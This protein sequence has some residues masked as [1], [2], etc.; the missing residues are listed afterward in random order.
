MTLTVYSVVIIISSHHHP[1]TA[2]PDTDVANKDPKVPGANRKIGHARQH[3]SNPISTFNFLLLNCTMASSLRVIEYDEDPSLTED[4][5]PHWEY[6]IS[7]SGITEKQRR[8]SREQHSHSTTANWFRHYLVGVPKQVLT[9]MFLPLGYPHSVTKEYM[10]YQI[11]DSLQGLCSYLRGVVSTSAVLT[12]AGVGNAEATAMSAAMTWAMRDG[13]GMIGGL[14]FSYS[15]SS[16]FDGYVKE[17]RLFADVINDVGLTLD[18]LA[19][20]FG[21]E[22]LLYVSSVATICKIMC[23]ISAGATKGSITQHFCTRGNMADLNAKEGTQEI[24]VSLIGM[25]LG[26]TL[27]SYLYKLEQK[28]KSLASTVSWTIFNLLTIVHVLVNYIGV[29]LLHLRTL[30]AQR[31]REA[32]QGLVDTAAKHEGVNNDDWVG[33]ALTKISSPD[34]I[35]ES[36]LASTSSML[37]PRGIILGARFDKLTK[38]LS[39]EDLVSQLQGNDRYLLGV[40]GKHVYVSLLVGAT[41]EDKLKAFVHACIV[42]KCLMRGESWRDSRRCMDQLIA[43]GFSLGLLEERGWDV[44][45]RLYIEFG[46]CRVQPVTKSKDE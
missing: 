22:N 29:K 5:K 38:V 26:V 40:S 27:A 30:N 43:K 33:D 6:S 8:F 1:D 37:F 12:A 25:I 13:V 39:V 10:N 24:L 9:D 7:S 11:C 36:L 32:L 46:R 15:T 18:M 2:R 34:A 19:P 16:Y 14:A 4:K 35:S 17:F 44:K 31:T 28:D 42:Q 21:S 20:Y 23:G 3:R 41:D 45:G